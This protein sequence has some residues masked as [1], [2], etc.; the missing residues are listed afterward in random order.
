MKIVVQKDDEKTVLDA[1]CEGVRFASRRILTIIIVT[2]S[3]HNASYVFDCLKIRVT[4]RPI[5]N[6]ILLRIKSM[7]F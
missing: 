6:I 4:R 1:L 7:F 5:N 3:R 2:F